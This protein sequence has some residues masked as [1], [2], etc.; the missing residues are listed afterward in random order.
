MA[1]FTQPDSLCHRDDKPDVDYPEMAAPGTR[2]KREADPDEK[3]QRSD[4]E[5]LDVHQLGAEI[6]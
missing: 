2:T 1:R 5:S 6:P 4:T 3:R